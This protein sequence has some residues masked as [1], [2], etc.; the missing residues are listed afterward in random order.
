MYSVVCLCAYSVYLGV[1]N[2]YLLV[3]R[4]RKGRDS[5][6]GRWSD[7]KVRRN[8]DTAASIHWCGKGF[9]LPRVKLSVQTL[10]RCSYSPRVQS[11]TSTSVRTLTISNTGSHTTVWTHNKLSK[12]NLIK[13]Y[14]R[15]KINSYLNRIIAKHV[16]ILDCRQNFFQQ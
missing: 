2:L 8:T 4:K 16:I 9:F 10:P 11:H 14:K 5:S 15:L 13:T 6:V 7:R 1:I 12:Q 3:P